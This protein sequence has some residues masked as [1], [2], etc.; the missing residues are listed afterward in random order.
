MATSTSDV[1]RRLE[2]CHALLDGHFQ[3]SS[4]LHSNRYV[5]CALLLARQRSIG[6]TL[7]LFD[8]SESVNNRLTCYYDDISTRIEIVKTI[9]GVAGTPAVADIFDELRGD[10]V[11][12]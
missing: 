9:G 12:G 7:V 2:E 6:S 8:I 3:L 1:Q 4:G 11:D 5:Q 10:L